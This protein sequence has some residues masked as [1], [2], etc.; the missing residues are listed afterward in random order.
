M[1]KCRFIENMRSY[2]SGYAALIGRPNV[3]KST[4]LNQLVATKIAAT[5]KSPQT[6]RVRII[7]VC[8]CADGQIILMDTPGI[9]RAKSRLN[10]AM[11]KTSLS[12]FS[13]VDLILFL[14]DAQ[15]GFQ[16]EDEYALE[17]MEKASG[18]GILVLNKIDLIPK[19]KLLPLM[20]QLRELK[21]FDEII[22][23]SALKKDGLDLLTDR[24]L[25]RL[26][27]GPSY[28]PKNMVTDCPE[29][30]LIGEIIREKA[31][32]LTWLE[33]PH[34]LAVVV[35]RVGPGKKSD[36]TVVYATLFTEKVS[37]KKI[38]IGHNGSMLKQ[39]GSL[40]RIEIEKR[41]G[42]KAYLNLH[43]GVKENWR[44]SDYYLK[45]FGYQ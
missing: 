27:E 42:G 39:I 8:H 11:V 40:A 10:R 18:P 41:F 19:D 5:S 7:G 31:T 14:I 4:L 17:A 3:G 21:K 28:F 37:Q 36:V 23:V 15:R 30:F 34:S 44:E 25:S 20:A 26:P 1:A 2:K 16:E 45:E 24:I 33:I 12:V 9:H 29:Q 6:T 38:L 13:D 43:V 22:P 35:E 32:R